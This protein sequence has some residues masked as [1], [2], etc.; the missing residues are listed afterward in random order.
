MIAIAQTSPIHPPVLPIS[1]SITEFDKSFIVALP[2]AICLIV[3]S[4]V[5]AVAPSIVINPCPGIGHV[6]I[7]TGNDIRRNARPAR[8][9]LKRLHPS[10]PNVILTTPI[11]NRAPMTTIQSGI[12]DGRLNARS[13]PVRIAEPSVIVGF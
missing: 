5:A 12:F 3:A 4:G 13:I 11:A 1:I 9:G 2:F 6:V 8:A 7:C 10:P